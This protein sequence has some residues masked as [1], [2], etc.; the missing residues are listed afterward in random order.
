MVQMLED[1]SNPLPQYGDTVDVCRSRTFIVQDRLQKSLSLCVVISSR[2]FFRDVSSL[3]IQQQGSKWRHRVGFLGDV[4]WR[5]F[6]HRFRE[7]LERLTHHKAVLEYEMRLQGQKML[8]RIHHDQARLNTMYENIQKAL[9]EGF[10]EVKQFPDLATMAKFNK[11]LD[12]QTTLIKT[13]VGASDYMSIYERARRDRM[14]GSCQWPLSMEDYLVWRSS[15]DLE[16][17]G[18]TS[19]AQ[20]VSFSERVLLLCAGTNVTKPRDRHQFIADALS[21]S[22]LDGLYKAILSRL[23]QKSTREKKLALAIFQW[24]AAAP[25]PLSSISLHTVLAVTPGEETSDLD[26]LVGFPECLPKLTGSL[27]EIN[28]FGRPSFIHLSVRELLVSQRSASVPS[29]SL[30]YPHLVHAQIAATCLSYLTHDVP[31]RPLRPLSRDTERRGNSTPSRK[32]SQVTQGTQT[33]QITK[34]MI[35]HEQLCRRCRQRIV[36]SDTLPQR[37]YHISANRSSP[38]YDYDIF[39]QQSEYP[40]VNSGQP[41][42]SQG[43]QKSTTHAVG[44]FTPSYYG[45]MVQTQEQQPNLPKQSP[46]VDLPPKNQQSDP[47]SL[48]EKAN[49]ESAADENDRD[50]FLY[51]SYPMLRYSAL[52]WTQHL[53]LALGETHQKYALGSPSI[54]SQSRRRA[55]SGDQWNTQHVNA[56][57]PSWAPH[58]SRF[59]LAR[60]CITNWVEC[61]F[62]Y[63]L[64]PTMARLERAMGS[65]AGGPDQTSPESREIHWIQHGINQVNEALAG[66][67]E[68][69]GPVLRENPSLIWQDSITAATDRHF[70]PVWYLEE[71]PCYTPLPGSCWERE[72]YSLPPVTRT[73]V[74]SGRNSS[75]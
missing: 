73:D 69:H 17:G 52:C 43:L 37:Q 65:V 49:R 40:A 12:Y 61:S 62:A 59:L 13:W 8:N 70:W 4:I 39:G 35:L 1:I 44:N 55:H 38:T 42:Y 34:G 22:G 75:S 14:E 24:I 72:T 3:N 16:P 71:P 2:I 63:H 33:D 51:T 47:S 36:L 66:L 20:H 60:P 46:P 26:Y 15:G 48:I 32:S 57:L 45:P 29:F 18:D 21:F 41:T 28:P 6:N 25:Y 11:D 27:V 50:L 9:H 56:P 23:D 58:L 54:L 67:D 53:W 5:T 64:Q 68:S 10:Q 74:L 7:L 31:R 30:K 19:L